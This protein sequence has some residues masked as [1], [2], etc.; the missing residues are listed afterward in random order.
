MGVAEKATRSLLKTVV[1]ADVV[2]VIKAPVR[3]FASSIRSE[4]PKPR[5]KAIED[6][7]RDEIKLQKSLQQEFVASRTAEEAEK[8]QKAMTQRIV[9]EVMKSQ[10][11][12]VQKAVEEMLQSQTQKSHK[13]VLIVGYG[14][15][16]KAMLPEWCK[17]SG[18]KYTIVNPTIYTTP[19]GVEVEYYQSPEGVKDKKFDAIIFGIKPQ[20]FEKVVPPYKDNLSESGIVI[21]IAAGV[22]TRKI[23]ELFEKEVAVARVMPNL[24]A[25]VGKSVNAW[26][27]NEYIS[28]EQSEFVEAL[29]SKTGMVLNVSEDKMN[30]VTAVSGSGPAYLAKFMQSWI[31]GA[32]EVGFTPKE[33]RELVLETV[34]GTAEFLKKIPQNQALE[35][36]EQLKEFIGNVTSKG[37]TTEAAFKKS[38][39]DGLFESL[40]V[41]AVKAANSRGDELS[42][43]AKP[44]TKTQVQ[45]NSTNQ[46]MSSNP[47]VQSK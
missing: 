21:S 45:Q 42:G 8:S 37:G 1:G 6:V 34:I 24:A 38:F 35:E 16:T 3:T 10:R 47:L 18:V 43:S 2:G 15:M 28:D 27:K 22:T 13:E 33:A 19:E 39:T 41:E 23:E 12:Q 36:E 32:K 29:M 40:V 7:I 20:N 31:K 17:V 9:E 30:G 4:A 26:A 5:Q 14:K 44:D 46:L 11:A 25:L